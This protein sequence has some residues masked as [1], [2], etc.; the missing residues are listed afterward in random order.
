MNTLIKFFYAIL[1]KSI[2]AFFGKSTSL[3]S[4][5]DSILRPN[6]TEIIVAEDLVWGSGKFRFFAP[7]KMAI[8]A[9]NKGIESKLLRNSLK[10][11][12]QHNIDKPVILDIGANYGFISLALQSNLNPATSIY[13]FEPHPEVFKVFQ[14]SI[15]ENNITNITSENVAIGSE[16]CDIMLNLYGQTSNILDSEISVKNKV[17][18]RQINLDNYL[19][20]KNIKPNFIKIDVDGYELNV[21]KGLKET[22]TNCKPIMVIETN[23]D[24]QVLDF[25]KNCGY[26]LLDLDLKEF[27]GMP[28]N[29]FC[30]G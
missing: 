11:I 12:A 7:I 8:K 29:V 3:K 24:Y 18:I 1:P 15:A 13:S 10:L 19:A 17:L 25:L 14:K 6:N 20:N 22:I 30:I 26:H 21:L 23:D 4:L 27:E 9:K 5:R 28:N 2:I 16:D